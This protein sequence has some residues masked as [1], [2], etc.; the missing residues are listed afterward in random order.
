MKSKFVILFAIVIICSCTHNHPGTDKS[1]A[2]RSLMKKFTAIELPKTISLND[3]RILK[4]SKT[5]EQNSFD[6]LFIKQNGNSLTYGYLKDTS[7]YYTLIYVVIG[8]E[9]YFRI[10]TFDKGFNMISDTSMLN[11]EGCIPGTLCLSCNT[12]INILDNSTIQ[13]IDSLNY[14]D[15]DSSGNYTDSIVKR[16]RLEQSIQIDKQGRFTI[17]KKQNSP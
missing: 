4:E 16:N 11:S 5:I 2:F 12:T 6:T 3:D 14:L 13:T 9:P 10:A 1:I 7:K 15:C 17:R 8:D